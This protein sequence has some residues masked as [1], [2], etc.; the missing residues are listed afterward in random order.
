MSGWTR[1]PGWWDTFFALS[2]E[3]S[4]PNAQR[5][6]LYDRVRSPLVQRRHHLSNPR[7][8]IPRRKRGWL[9]GLPWIDR[10]AGLHPAARRDVCV[11]VAILSVAPARRRLR[12]LILRIDQFHL[13]VDRR[14]PALS[15]RC[16]RARPQGH[17]GA[18]HQPHVGSASVVPARAPSAER[19]ARAQLVRVER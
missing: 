19:L 11:A 7:E 10:T 17:H 4:A 14:F 16:A 13:R 15:R 1:S 6:T 8:V 18:R 9:W 3:R 5:S 2:V 12:H